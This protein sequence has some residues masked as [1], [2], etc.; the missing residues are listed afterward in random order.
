MNKTAISK[1]SSGTNI[2]NYLNTGWKFAKWTDMWCEHPHTLTHSH[3]H[4]TCRVSV[5]LHVLFFPSV[6]LRCTSKL[7]CLIHT[8]Y[9]STE[10]Y[11]MIVCECMYFGWCA[12]STRSKDMENPC[13]ICH[14]RWIFICLARIVRSVCA[15]YVEWYVTSKMEY[16]RGPDDAL[17]R[18]WSTY[19]VW[20]QRGNEARKKVHQCKFISV[21]TRK[22]I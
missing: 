19:A 7:R 15:P 2:I 17:W 12:R 16:G 20:S 14:W 10:H 8:S 22:Q 3:L 6:P 18:N 5:S 13:T 11:A 21:K 4:T 9:V 1:L